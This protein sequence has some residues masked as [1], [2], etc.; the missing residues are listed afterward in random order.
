[1]S[2]TTSDVNDATSETSEANDVKDTMNG[3]HKEATEGP[4]AVTMKDAET[5]SAARRRTR[6]S[7][8]EETAPSAVEATSSA[9]PAASMITAPT[10]IVTSTINTSTPAVPTDTAAPTEFA[11]PTTRSEGLRLRMKVW[12]D[13]A[14]GKRYL[15]PTAMPDPR[16]GIL[17]A[18]AM[19]D[20]DTRIVRLT[21]FEWNALP[22]FYFKEDGPAS[23][24][25]KRPVD[26]LR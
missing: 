18:Y 14:T 1:M 24:A 7:A 20:E 10:E 2:D 11:A 8:K 15:M 4:N 13:L 21:P 12:T 17:T 3:T 5:S 16:L 19:S 25:S 9:E 26:V 22:F 6:R 23:R